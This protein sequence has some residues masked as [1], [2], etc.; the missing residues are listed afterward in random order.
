MT[1][2]DIIA[3]ASA[4]VAALALAQSWSASRKAAEATREA[5]DLIKQQVALQDR[6]TQIEQSREHAK[7][8][9]SLR[10]TIRAV[11]RKTDRGSWRLFVLNTGQGTARNVTLMLDGKPL[12][13]HDAV[14]RG[15]QE[16]RT[17]GPDSDVSYCMAISS[18]CHPPF[19]LE[20][21]WDDDSGQQG[22]YGTTLTF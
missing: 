2:T 5:N 15:E 17:I 3:I 8:I 16:A 14:P 4:C 18:G 1:A 9:Q 13:E 6:L 21:T 11:L 7:L 10:A 20:A 19:E 22:T 12:L